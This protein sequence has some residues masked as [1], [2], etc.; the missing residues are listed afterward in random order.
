MKVTKKQFAE[1]K[2]EFKRQAARLGLQ[3]CD[4]VFSFEPLEDSF[5]S[6]ASDSEGAVATIALNSEVPEEHFQD[7]NVPQHAI[8]EALE[9]LL[10]RIEVLAQSRNFNKYEW[11]CEKHRVIRTLE[12]L[13]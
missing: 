5:A 3:G 9:L 6:C 13:L 12:K 7:L 2:R 4:V 11:D 1:F 10:A 8:H